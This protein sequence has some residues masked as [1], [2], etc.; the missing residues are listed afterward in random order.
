MCGSCD[1]F[2]AGATIRLS[3]T[4]TGPIRT[5]HRFPNT[6]SVKIVNPSIFSN[7]VLCPSQAACSP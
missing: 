5:P 3:P 7:T 4:V 6:G 2:I 1:R